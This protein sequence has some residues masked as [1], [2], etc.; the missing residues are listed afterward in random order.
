MTR[1]E[2]QAIVIVSLLAAFVNGDKHDRKRAEIKRIA[3]GLAQAEGVPL[4]TLYQDVLMKRV[5]LASALPTLASTESRHLAYE[6]AVC[7]CDAD[8]AQAAAEKAFLAE[9]RSALELDASSA[10]RFTEQAEALAT[11][12]LA[13]PASAAAPAARTDDRAGR[14]HPQCRHRQ[15]RARTAAQDALHHGD[16][17]AADEAGLPPRQGARPRARPW[18]REGLPRHGRRRADLAVPGAGRPQALERPA[19]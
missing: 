13:S 5:T 12:P 7:V 6:M 8:G 10:G 17:S 14:R 19:A 1:S 4:P 18:S 11:V 2:I 15:R 9:L 3:E 16:H